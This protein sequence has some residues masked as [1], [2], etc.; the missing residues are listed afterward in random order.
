MWGAGCGVL[1]TGWVFM[2][3]CGR[4]VQGGVV[5]DGY[6]WGGV[7]DR[8]GASVEWIWDGYRVGMEWGMGWVWDG[9]GGGYG[10]CVC[11]CVLADYEGR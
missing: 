2:G 11:V 9:L 6:V 4:A 8:Y 5:G 7:W 10:V 1:D 3:G